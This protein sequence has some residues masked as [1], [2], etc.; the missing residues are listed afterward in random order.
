MATKTK[1]PVTS[2]NE[3]TERKMAVIKQRTGTRVEAD[4][5]NSSS[6]KS[7]LKIMIM[8]N[9]GGNQVVE[10]DKKGKK[11]KNKKDKEKDK[12]KAEKKKAQDKEKA[13]K[14]KVEDNNRGKAINDVITN[15]RAALVLFQEIR[16]KSS[17]NRGWKGHVW[18]E[19]LQYTGHDEASILF[20][21]NEVT[22]EE[23][24]Q[25]FLDDTL[26]DLIRMGD[27]QQGFTPIPRM[28]LRKIK[29]KG[30]PI[31]E[32]ICISWHGRHNKAK[33]E[34][35]KEEFKSMLKYILKLSEKESLPV[36][37]AGDYNVKIKNIETLVPPSLV[38]HKYKPSE[39]R[40]PENIIDFF[41]SSYSLVMSDI[42]ALTLKSET[43]V[44]GVLS[45]FDHD[46]VVL[47]M[48]T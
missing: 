7:H 22:L 16:W 32:F 31:V 41:I 14:N 13:E 9:T 19:N 48:S 43:D 18:P 21:I 47:S 36:I 24:P 25:Q 35:L 42:N 2:E 6:T 38:L 39:R 23:Y 46:P 8:N 15:T 11:G 45:L 33:L 34:D 5:D 20:D 27:I 4:I 26:R 37:V 28:C 3:D 1:I 44:M 30:V 29:T 40:A 10:K 17:R 12:E